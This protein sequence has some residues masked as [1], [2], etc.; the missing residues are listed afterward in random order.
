M[1]RMV[2]SDE[3]RA[4]HANYPAIDLHADTL[5]WTRWVGYDLHARHAPPLPL[6]ALG[7][8]VDLPRMRGA[9][10]RLSSSGWCRSRCEGGGR[11]PRRR[12]DRRA[13]ETIERRPH[14]LRLV[15]TDELEACERDVS[16]RAA[17]ASRAHAG[18]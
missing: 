5:M 6:A 11:G 10:W 7:G 15:K 8:H 17:P 1:P 16:G 18:G 2:V 3:A 13:V 4:V 12:A 9:G 14:A